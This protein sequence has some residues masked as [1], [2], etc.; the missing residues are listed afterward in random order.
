[1]VYEVY[2]WT[3]DMSLSFLFV[4]FF[5]FFYRWEIFLR[6]DRN[7]VLDLSTVTE[8]RWSRETWTAHKTAC[9]M[10]RVCCSLIEF[11]NLLCEWIKQTVVKLVSN[12]I[13]YLIS[14]QKNANDFFFF[15]GKTLTI[16]A[17][18]VKEEM[19]NSGEELY[20]RI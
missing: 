15:R 9:S 4:K 20:F 2:F 19:Y 6:K 17:D 12:V 14:K 16:I 7:L 13:F 5:L 8:K 1:M 10:G 3:C 11:S 18:F